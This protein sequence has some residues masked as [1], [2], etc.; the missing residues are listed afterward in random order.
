MPESLGKKAV[1]GSI[2]LSASSLFTRVLAAGRL[3]ILAAILPQTELGLFGMAI[4][5]MQ[6]VEQLSQTGMRQALIQ[7]EGDIEDYLGTAWTSQ[8]FRGLLLGAVLFFCA[9]S[10]ESFFG[11]AGLATLMRWL[12]LLPIMQGFFNMGFVYLN[13]ELQFDKVV[14]QTTAVSLIDNVLSIVLAF[15]WPFAIVLVIGR[16]IAIA[17]GI[18]SL[19]HI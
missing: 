7:R 13:R 9:E 17:V 4:V 5:V 3:L 19:I 18:V 10:I 11:K 6:L 12:A 16:L 8:I 15:I 1:R 2:W 14:I